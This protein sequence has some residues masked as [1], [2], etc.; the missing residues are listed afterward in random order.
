MR[1][2]SMTIRN[3]SEF[4]EDAKVYF[5]RQRLGK[6]NLLGPITHFGNELGWLWNAAYTVSIA[7]KIGIIIPIR[8]QMATP[9]VKN[10]FLYPELNLLVTRDSNG[11]LH[12]EPIR[13]VPDYLIGNICFTGYIEPLYEAENRIGNIKDYLKCFDNNPNSDHNYEVMLCVSQPEPGTSEPWDFSKKEY[14]EHGNPVFVGHVFLVLKESAGLKK[15]IRNVGFYPEGNVWPY[16]PSNQGCLNNDSYI[17]YNVALNI[18]VNCHQFN[19]IL[20]YLSMGN[21]KGFMYNLNSNNCTN[22]ALDAL[23]GAEIVLPRSIGKWHHGSGLNPGNLGE[24][25]RKMKLSRDM[26]LITNYEAHGNQGDCQ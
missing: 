7:G 17:S 9:Y 19:Q 14:A 8:N 12:P 10:N 6:G 4:I 23:R 20:S 2:Y 13:V 25:I 16:A 22:F 21:N 3:Y 11:Q 18:K 24:D 26:K 5:Q 15:I 1:R